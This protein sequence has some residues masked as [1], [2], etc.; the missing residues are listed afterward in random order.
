MFSPT[1]TANTRAQRTKVPCLIWLSIFLICGCKC[2]IRSA[3][4]ILSV[5]LSLLSKTC[6]R[7]ALPQSAQRCVRASRSMREGSYQ[8]ARTGNFAGP[9]FNE[10]DADDGVATPSKLEP[11]EAHKVPSG[12]KGQQRVEVG[13]ECPIYEMTTMGSSNIT[14][15]DNISMIQKTMQGERNAIEVLPL[16]ISTCF[17]FLDVHASLEAPP[18]L[19][20]QI[21]TTSRISST[22]LSQ[23]PQIA[24]AASKLAG[25]T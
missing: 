8:L 19:R 14:S 24:T 5:S 1:W 2:N 9:F 16:Q 23:A 6:D 17:N 22:R 11:A 7:S 13:A 21:P 10:L 15:N 18:T 3:I 4:S 20:L 25:H 12:S